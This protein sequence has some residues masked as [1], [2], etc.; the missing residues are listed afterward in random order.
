MSRFSWNVRSKDVSCRSSTSGAAA[1]SRA[2]RSILWVGKRSLKRRL[3]GSRS[4]TST[5]RKAA[6]YRLK[7]LVNAHEDAIARHQ[8]FVDLIAPAAR[9]IHA[10]W[11]AR[12][13]PGR[14]EEHTS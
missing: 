13:A 12:R 1:T 10:H 14:S 3:T 4:S 6:E 5:S 7:E 11:L 9:N 2:S 8:A